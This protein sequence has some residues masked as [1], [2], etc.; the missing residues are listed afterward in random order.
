MK[1]KEIYA[2]KIKESVDMDDIPNLKSS[3]RKKTKKHEHYNFGKDIEQ[4]NKEEV[5]D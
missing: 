4:A 3:K 2:N 1:D 5:D